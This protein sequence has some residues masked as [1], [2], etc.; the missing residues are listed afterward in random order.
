MKYYKELNASGDTACAG[1]VLDGMELPDGV[2]EVSAQEYQDVLAAFDAADAERIAKEKA[3]AEAKAKAE[4]EKLKAEQEAA[5]KAQ[6]E[7]QAAIN[8][9]VAQVKAGAAKL[10]DVPEDYR[11]DVDFIVNPPVV[12][13]TNAELN[14]RLEAAESAVDFLMTTVAEASAE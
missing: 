10:E 9:Y 8:D 13:P 7:R 3:D 1:E 14:T 2:E 11:D 6:Q 4:D 5:E 12:P